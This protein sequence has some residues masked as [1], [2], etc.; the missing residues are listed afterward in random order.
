MIQVC[1]V[2]RRVPRFYRVVLARLYYIRSTCR[3]L[4]TL[5]FLIGIALCNSFVWRIL[6]LLFVCLSVCLSVC[7]GPTCTETAERIWL[8]FCTATEV[9]ASRILV[10]VAAWVQ[11][12]E[13]MMYHREILRQ[14]CA[15]HLLSFT[16]S[17]V[18]GENKMSPCS[19]VNTPMKI[20]D[21]P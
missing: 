18:F 3:T 11:P 1:C 15:Y 16:H 20:A 6:S 4:C 9:T 5:L 12:G 8:K 21:I 2:A 13:P 19:V 7:S 14:S 10:S 17:L